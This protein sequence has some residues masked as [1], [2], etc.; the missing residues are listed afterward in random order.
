MEE[1]LPQ[2][3][4]N[5]STSKVPRFTE[6]YKPS[7]RV[8]ATPNREVKDSIPIVPFTDTIKVPNQNFFVLSYAAPEGAR[9]K[10]KKIAIKVSGAFNTQKEAEEHAEKIRNSN[11]KFD[12]YVCNMYEWGTVPIPDDVK[13]FINKNYTDEYLTRVLRGQEESMKQS[14]KE[15]QERMARDRAKAEEEVKK[16][17]G[18]NYVM[19]KKADITAEYEKESLK[20]EVKNTDIN[21][22]HR[23]LLESFASFIQTSKKMDPE[24]VKEFIGFMQAK[25]D[26]DNEKK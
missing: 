26:F 4:D 18:P 21:Y 22:S 9:V 19:P 14:K 10:A 7:N 15:M 17:Y 11:N 6:R 5:K 3:K 8:F 25:K 12:V 2:L 16:A 1:R 23:E 20:A 13:P 24:V